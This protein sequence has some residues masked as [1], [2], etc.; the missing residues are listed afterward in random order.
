[1]LEELQRESET[2]Q[3]PVSELVRQKLTGNHV[4]NLPGVL[5]MTA[6]ASKADG[7]TPA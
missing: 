5:A 4:D 7:D 3:A 2:T 1:L 6:Q